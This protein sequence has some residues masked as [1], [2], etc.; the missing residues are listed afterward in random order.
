MKLIETWKKRRTLRNLK[1]EHRAICDD[2]AY[3]RYALKRAIRS[4]DDKLGSALREAITNSIAEC[5]VVRAKIAIINDWLKNA[6]T[7]NAVMTT[8]T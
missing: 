7:N 1:I 6:K 3:Y 8:E 4:E 5:N 2:M